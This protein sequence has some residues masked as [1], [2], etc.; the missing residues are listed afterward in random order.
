MRTPKVVILGGGFGGVHTFLSLK[1]LIKKGSIEVALVSREDYFLFTPLLHEVVSGKVRAES[2]GISISGFVKEK[3]CAFIQAEVLSVDLSRKIVNTDFGFISYDILVVALGSSTNLFGIDGAEFIPALKTLSDAKYIQGE[4]RGLDQHKRIAII[5]GGASGIEIAAELAD[6]FAPHKK[7]RSEIFILEASDDIL[8]ATHPGLKEMAKRSLSKRGV[9]IMLHSAVSR[10]DGNCIE[11]KS[12]RKIYF[13][14]AIWT[15]GVKASDMSFLPRPQK[16][17]SN[18]LRVLSTMQ[19]Q[20]FSCVFALG[21]IADGYPMTAQVA[22]SQAKI[23]SKNIKAIIEGNPLSQFIYRPMGMLF[24]LGR[25]M[26]GAEIKIHLLNK[27]LYFWGPLG[28]FIWHLAYVS[29][30]PGMRNKAR[31]IWDWIRTI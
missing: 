4:L 3:G 1:G 30:I 16:S 31:I 10:I 25:W 24:S 8:P 6:M 13:D 22:V 23:V 19:L 12:G 26:A 17:K 7:E 18:R 9:R 29:K 15:A 14:L 28:W 20:D 11:L 27:V 2:A 5:G 21:D